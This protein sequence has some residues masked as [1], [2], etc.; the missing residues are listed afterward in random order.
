M[1]GLDQSLKRVRGNDM[2]RV[3]WA[4]HG[5]VFHGICSTCKSLGVP[6]IEIRNNDSD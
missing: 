1:V 2:R 3:M 4:L 6:R 5:K